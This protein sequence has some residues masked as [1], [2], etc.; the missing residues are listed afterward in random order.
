MLFICKNRRFSMLF[1]KK[2]IH[3]I[4]LLL[5]TVSMAFAGCRTSEVSR[6]QV[7]E[8]EKVDNQSQKAYRKEYEAA[9]KKHH[10]MQSD[11]TK[12]MMKQRKKQQK[13]YNKTHQRSLWDRIFKRKC[14]TNYGNG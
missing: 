5:L 12:E 14:K 9:V 11:R 10:D 7:Q 2:Y 8:L 1:L 6:E 13:Q 4:F 3:L